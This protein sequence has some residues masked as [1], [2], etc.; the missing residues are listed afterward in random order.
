[1][2]SK[3]VRSAGSGMEDNLSLDA[4]QLCL[5]RQ[6]HGLRSRPAFYEGRFREGFLHRYGKRGQHE[7]PPDLT[8]SPNPV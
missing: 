3:I 1:V 7:T 8:A 4:I 6:A 5:F 2:Q